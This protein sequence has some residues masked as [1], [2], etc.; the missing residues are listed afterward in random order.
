[1]NLNLIHKNALVGGGSKGLGKAAAIELAKL[2]AN[3]TLISRNKEILQKALSELPKSD[4]QN[5]GFIV[6]DNQSNDSIVRSSL[7]C[8]KIHTRDLIRVYKGR[9]P[10]ANPTKG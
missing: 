6:L 4:G 1:M 3:I 10:E 7:C 2:G 8:Q 5:H 9:R